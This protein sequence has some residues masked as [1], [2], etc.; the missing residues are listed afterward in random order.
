M[1][2]KI[3]FFIFSVLLIPLTFMGCSQTDRLLPIP[4]NDD[5]PILPNGHDWI[6]DIDVLIS[7]SRPAEV[8]VRT[9]GISSH[10]CIP[11]PL[12]IHYKRDADTIYVWGTYNTD[13]REET[14]IPED[15]KVCTTLVTPFQNQISIG[16][17]EVG[18]YKVI[19]KNIELIFGIENDRSWVSRS[20][21]LMIEFEVFINPP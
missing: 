21:P 2:N 3:V 20:R 13:V 19:T 4:D 14:D 5:A 15:P 9:F 7:E 1:K 16:K 12:E 17:F 10:G 8:W 18:E 6:E 11:F